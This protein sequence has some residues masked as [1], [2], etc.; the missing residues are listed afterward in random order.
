MLPFV[1]PLLLLRALLC[2]LSM[3]RLASLETGLKIML[4]TFQSCNS[5]HHIQVL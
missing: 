5:H 4:L 3:C 1:L 2:F